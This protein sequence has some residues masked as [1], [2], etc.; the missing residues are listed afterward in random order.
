MI[1]VITHTVIFECKIYFKNK[2]FWLIALLIN[3]YAWAAFLLAGQVISGVAQMFIPAL[4]F[5]SAEVVTKD[6]RDDFTEIIYT[7]PYKNLFLLGGRALAVLLLFLFL[8][9]ELLLTMLLVAN[10]SLPVY[11]SWS[12]C[13]AFMVKYLVACINVI[14]ITFMVFS[15]TKNAVRL[16][17]LLLFWWLLG[18]FLTGNAGVLFPQ[19]VAIVNF[20]FIHGFGGNPSEVTGVYPYDGVIEAIIFFQITW[21]VILFTIAVII[22]NVR[23]EQRKNIIRTCLP[24]FLTC[25][26]IVVL[27][28]Y[29]TW[30]YLEIE[31]SNDKNDSTISR[32]VLLPRA[33]SD[34]Q[35]IFPAAYDLY[36]TLDSNTH[37]M[38]VKAQ[39]TLKNLGK[40]SP[41]TIEFTL[42][43]Y[44]CVQRVVNRAT[45]EALVWQQ[46]GP[47][48]TV[49]LPH[50]SF[51]AT[52]LLTVEISYSGK[53][54]EWAEDIYGQ[55]TGLV[56]FV[57]SPFTF[58]RG[59]YAWY[60]VLGRQPLHSTFSYFSPWTNQPKQLKQSVLVTH[61]PVPFKMTVE[62][63]Q[64]VMFIS[65][66]EFKKKV[67]DGT[68]QRNEFTSEAGRDVFLLAGPYE[69]TKIV[70]AGTDKLVDFYHFSNHDYN[71]NNMAYKVSQIDYYGSL[72]PRGGDA[73]RSDVKNGYV[74][75]EAPRFLTY[76]SLM[77]TS[78]LGVIDAISMPEAIFLTKALY[79]PWWSQSAG[80]ILSEARSLNLWWPNCFSKPKGDIADGLALYMYILYTENKQGKKFYDHAR[81]YWL[82]YNEKS[83][84]NEEMLGQRGRIVQEI[85]LLLDSIR[86]SNL[87]D[88][89]VRQFLR[90]VNRRYQ[91]KRVIEIADMVDALELIGALKQHD[92]VRKDAGSR[93]DKYRNSI[94]TL[95]HH[96]KNPPENRIR[97]TL[98][99]KLNWDFGAQITNKEAQ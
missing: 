62:S 54:W 25:S 15:L 72:V 51:A 28:F 11:I 68:I 31:S 34:V 56:N 42:R 45:G 55:S 1:T 83:P 29:T 36:I 4:L 58:L 78:N 84:D 64:D 13:W 63:D 79:S 94:N 61:I 33:N 5:L 91:D 81:E 26:A 92:D 8:G 96:L 89:G 97:S 67:R 32:G 74:I 80:R 6:Q 71:L 21:S 16:Y 30:Q 49:N 23:R 27:T 70:V 46:Q 37:N 99:F 47:T 52:E 3:A 77:N 82:F 35:S 50:G 10:T 65:N 44:L 95:S 48:V 7:L 85:F 40:T 76:D 90:F 59:G 2:K 19:W 12:A 43:D 18:V 9:I 22:E 20:T 17:F 87:G 41:P 53:V 60:P 73:A 69:H 24:L 14:G 39:I 66:I 88:D 57:A 98:T 38:V 86:Q 93:D 75:F